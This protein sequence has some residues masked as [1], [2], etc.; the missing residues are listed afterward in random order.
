MHSEYVSNLS[1]SPTQEVRCVNKKNTHPSWCHCNCWQEQ[2][3][4]FTSPLV[5]T[6]GFIFFQYYTAC[7][8]MNGT[9]QEHV[10]GVNAKFSKGRSWEYCTAK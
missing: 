3:R 9:I 5:A 4:P 1:P 7:V 2:G 6:I 8:S 10:A